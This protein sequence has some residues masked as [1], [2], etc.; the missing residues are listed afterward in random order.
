[1]MSLGSVVRCVLISLFLPLYAR[2][3]FQLTIMARPLNAGAILSIWEGDTKMREP[4][5]L[6]SRNQQIYA[7][8]LCS[9]SCALGITTHIKLVLLH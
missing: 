9:P 5:P 6:R 4:Q 2:S 1:M 7:L 3:L 8:I